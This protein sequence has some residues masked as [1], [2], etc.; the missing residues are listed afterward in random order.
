MEK[1]EGKR[2]KIRILFYYEFGRGIV[3]LGLDIKLVFRIVSR[4]RPAPPAPP[5][6]PNRV[7]LQI[8]TNRP[9]QST[10]SPSNSKSPPPDS[11][12]NSNSSNE[13]RKSLHASRT[14]SRSFASRP[15]KNYECI[16]ETLLKISDSNFRK[17]FRFDFGAKIIAKIEIDWLSNRFV[18]SGFS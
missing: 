11:N 12:S 14:T 18:F 13:R 5:P 6:I 16:H 4:Y 10:V 1:K 17:K 2:K 9:R 8:S 3:I 15:I 7:S